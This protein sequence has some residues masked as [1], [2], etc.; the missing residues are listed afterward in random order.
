MDEVLHRHGA[1]FLRAM[2][3]RGSLL[4]D[5]GYLEPDEL[6]ASASRIADGTPAPGDNSVCNVIALEAALSSFGH[7]ESPTPVPA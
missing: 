7:A 6:A 2:L 5:D 1:A 4:I 3:D